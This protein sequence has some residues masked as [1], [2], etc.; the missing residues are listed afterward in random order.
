MR[1]NAKPGPDV[2]NATFYKA[3]WS[4]IGDYIYSLVRSFYTNK[5]LPDSFKKT[6]IVLIPKKFVCLTPLDYRPISLCNV[7]YK[8]IAKSLALKMQPYLRD[9]IMDSQY[10]FV[11]GRRISENIILGHEIIHSFRQKRWTTNAF[12]L[13][14]DLAKA[15]DRLEWSF[16]KYAL[17][18]IGFCEYFIDLIVACIEWPIFSVIINGQSFGNFKGSTGIRQGCPLSLYLF[19]SSHE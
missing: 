1:G 13:K 10:A 2:F 18:R 12:M 4:W 7:I 15:F 17:K 19:Y 16:I 8:I 11:K 14:L 5:W 6:N 9:C 3:T